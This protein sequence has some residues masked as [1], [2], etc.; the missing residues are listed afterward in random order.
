MKREPREHGKEVP[1]VYE[2]EEY[3]YEHRISLNDEDI[4]KLNLKL[5]NAGDIL[6]L[7]AKVEVKRVSIEEEDEK[8]EKSIQLQITHMELE[9]PS[10]KS[11]SEIIFSN[12]K[13]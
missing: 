10:I 1:E 11:D 13:S 4:K 6:N 9:N 2:E 12:A 8:K 5:P 3:S 7:N